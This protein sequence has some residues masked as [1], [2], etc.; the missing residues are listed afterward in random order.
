MPEIIDLECDSWDFKQAN[1]GINKILNNQGYYAKVRKTPNGAGKPTTWELFATYKVTKYMSD[2]PI[3]DVISE[4]LAKTSELSEA[5]VKTST[6]YSDG[7]HN[8]YRHVNFDVVVTGWRMLDKSEV[9]SVKVIMDH[10]EAEK[11][12]LREIKKLEDMA[13]ELRYGVK[14]PK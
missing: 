11:A 12:K 5:K 4:L 9:K 6:W 8:D 14:R 10:M 2:T 7:G 3:D 1:P 13:F